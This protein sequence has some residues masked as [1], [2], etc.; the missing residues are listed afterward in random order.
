[1]HMH[2][3]K[4]NR[5][6]V[7]RGSGLVGNVRTIIILVGQPATGSFLGEGK[8]AGD[9]HLL[10]ALSLPTSL[11][12]STQLPTASH[13]HALTSTH[14]PSIHTWYTHIL[15]HTYKS[16]LPPFLHR[17]ITTNCTLLS[18]SFCL[19]SLP[20]AVTLISIISPPS[21]LYILYYPSGDPGFSPALLKLKSILPPFPQRS[22]HL[23]PAPDHPFT[24]SH[25]HC[26]LRAFQAI[27]RR[28]CQ[29]RQKR[30]STQRN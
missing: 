15:S 14:H 19:S 30:I 4:G 17:L 24:Q 6:V 29:R 16:L 5:W 13:S 21:L 11:I 8:H 3:T 23:C 20:S 18:L 9:L 28:Y 27:V 10:P 12:P 22:L 1:M 7:E 2:A 25:A 26:F